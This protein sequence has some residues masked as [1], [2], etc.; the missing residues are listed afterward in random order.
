M[1]GK[2]PAVTDGIP[3]WS[4]IPGSRVLLM[5]TG[6]HAPGS[7]LPDVPAVAN[8]VADLAQAYVERCG[9]PRSAVHTA[10][11]PATPMELGDA[12]AAAAERASGLLVVH[13]VGHG[14]LSD[15]GVLHLATCSTDPRPTRLPHTSLPY[16]TMR[17]YLRQYLDGGPHRRLVVVLDCCYSGRATEGLDGMDEVMPLAD[18]SGAYVIASAGRDEHA[19]APE[20]SRHTA[21]SGA[22]LRLLT[23]GDPGGPADFTL[24]HTFRHLQRELPA[25]GFPRPRRLTEGRTGELI[26][27]ANPS[28][29][30]APS[31]PPS[32]E[33]GDHNGA[34]ETSVCP[35]KGLAAFETADSPWFFGRES[36]TRTLTDALARSH[37]DGRVLAVLGASGSG[38]SSLL[39]AGLLPALSRGE[40]GIAGSATWPRVLLT[41]T[42]DLPAA[43]AEALSGP[44]GIPARRLAE[45]LAEDPLRL[46]AAL[47]AGGGRTPVVIVVDQ[48]E[49]VFTLAESAGPREAFVRAL[50]AAA[51]GDEHGPAALVVLGVRADFYAECM[52]VPELVPSLREQPVVVGPMSTA[53]L[54]DTVEKPAARAGFA[55]EPGL[56]DV[57]LGDLG[58]SPLTKSQ[59]QGSYDAGRLPLLSHALKTAWQQRT[60]P[61][62]T[63]AGYKETGRIHGA[64]A[65]TA[66][67]AMSRLDEGGRDAARG[68]LLRLVRIGEGTEATKRRAA[69]SEL[70]AEVPD[71]ERAAAVLAAFTTEDTRLITMERD[72]VE[73]IHETLLHAWPQLRTWIAENTTRLRTEQQLTE[74]AHTWERA[75]RDPSLLQTG[76][77]LARAE[78]WAA[79]EPMDSGN[80]LAL[81]FVR[82]GGRRRRRSARQRR[83]A[84]AVV[85]CVLVAVA[86]S[87]GVLFR[88]AD[89][90]RR[91]AQSQHRTA[92]ARGLVF[93]AESLRATAPD[94]A[95]RLGIAAQRLGPGDDARA[96]LMT[97]LLTRHQPDLLTAHTGPVKA[98]ACSDDGHT[99]ATA[100]TD[101]AVL[102]WDTSDRA[103]P[104]R[105][106]RLTGHHAPVRAL[107][108]APGGA[109]LATGGEDRTIILWDVS[110]PSEPRRL[111]SITGATSTIEAIAVSRD[112]HTLLSG[113]A[114]RFGILWDI[115]DLGHP[116]RTA[117]LEGGTYRQVHG[118]ALTP[119]GRTAVVDG[120][121]ES[122]YI[123]KISDPKRPRRIGFAPGRGA[124]EVY[125]VAIAPDGHTLAVAYSDNEVV[126]WDIRQLTTTD[127]QRQLSV[128]RAH[129]RPVHGLA[130]SP[131][132]RTL[133]TAS[134]DHTALLWNVTDQA[135][136]RRLAVLAG[137]TGPVNS[138]TFTPD[139]RTVV[140]GSDD[141]TAA[142]WDATEEVLPHPTAALSA[143]DGRV[144]GAVLPPGAPALAAT[145]DGAGQHVVLWEVTEPDRRRRLASVPAAQPLS[146][147]FSPD[148][149]R[150]AVVDDESTKVALYDLTDPT[151]PQHASTLT[152]DHG[153]VASAVYG[154]DGRT[155]ATVT[156]GLLVDDPTFGT[157]VI[158]AGKS[159][160]ILWDIT[161]PTRPE[162]VADIP[163]GLNGYVVFSPDRRTLL[164]VADGEAV[165][166]WDVRILAKPRRLG[167]VGTTGNAF[168][169]DPAAAFTPDGKILALARDDRQA[170]VLYD[171]TEPNQPKELAS[172]VGHADTPQS[173]AFGAHGHL[174]AT[175]ANDGTMILWDVTVPSTPRQLTTV[176]G[177]TTSS[178]GHL[179]FSPDTRTLV[180]I[181][182]DYD[183]PRTGFLWDV[184]PITQSLTA[185]TTRA[186]AL[187]HRGLNPAEW[188][189]ATAGLPY[190]Q[191]CPA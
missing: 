159:V 130:F 1:V 13:Y 22:L 157:P 48:F 148:G 167:S 11:D 124:E 103:R 181:E 72:S 110:D 132:A 26:V 78:A 84:V 6:R 149:K 117:T 96:S 179:A 169:G 184:T 189:K 142:L 171:I 16:S 147:A 3:R 160:T 29:R 115:T 105:V 52:A 69:R 28:Y 77:R 140:T 7:S 12:I 144:L 178:F 170:A 98:V 138:V 106:A 168:E 25:A 46:L 18:I 83:T 74:A 146:V 67:L 95:V 38:K 59:H 40:L 156:Q 4:S 41:P 186:C 39:R 188:Q 47:R 70:L 35:Y 90:Q 88:S 136:P 174:I 49:E 113:G 180:N 60:G 2:H 81:E 82:A 66:E 172:L 135:H 177:P 62:L 56:V 54:R 53:E 134:A 45:I 173:L 187:V 176:T 155:L 101:H 131:D 133:A 5:G 151:K 108:F 141:G 154:P 15:Q 165:V 30:A 109:L 19:L 153:W 43:L 158:D 32:T 125:A 118:V 126:L 114:G 50:H 76:S 166:L 58:A 190:Q 68:L 182:T 36:L 79:E 61:I 121:G 87:L 127:N 91:E 137:H 129:T 33:G 123:W 55:L 51:H 37:D 100:G 111:S 17:S 14:L 9:I 183:E 175:S 23:S 94:T 107:A 27:A 64:L 161:R 75:G 150:M 152:N 120:A 80:P 185:P 164:S 86:T 57:L 191:T 99:T 89:A 8:T 143:P 116:R 63:V 34:V 93:Q 21:F 24:D 112:R 31:A 92:T 119:D 65:A 97:T 102:L 139:G 104:R 122:P 20:G 10:L 44:T 162:H 128:I 73:I 163:A 42:A 85:L 71:P 145:L